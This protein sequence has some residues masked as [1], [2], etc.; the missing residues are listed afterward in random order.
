M[1][2]D[3]T[4][5]LGRV[6]YRQLAELTKQS[7]CCLAIGTHE[8]L[9]GA[10]GIFNPFVQAVHADA[11]VDTPF[12]QEKGVIQIARSVDAGRLRSV[13]RPEIDWSQLEDDEIYE[14]IVQHEL[15]HYRSNHCI[16][17]IFEIHDRDIHTACHR[18]IRAV[19]EVLADRFA[20][21]A[22]RPSEPV[23]LCETGKRLQEQMVEALALLDKH[24]PRSR[25]TPH[26][27]PAGQYLYVPRSMLLTDW[28]LAYVGPLVSPEL[29]ERGRS[30]ERARRGGHQWIV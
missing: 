21:N 23:P 13:Q 7:G 14:F 12:L 16:F 28:R 6:Q 15:G 10:W 1:K 27:L 20:W 5:R 9:R 3:T 22:I 30:Y 8:E 11:C 4:L 24:A 29:V 25:I 2:T 26:V 18:V 17:K 19:N